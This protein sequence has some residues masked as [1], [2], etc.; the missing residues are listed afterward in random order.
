M[1]RLQLGVHPRV[2]AAHSRVM[3]DRAMGVE[4]LVVE[5]DGMASGVVAALRRLRIEGVAVA[6][7]EDAYAVLDSTRGWRGFLVDPKLGPPSDAGS[8]LLTAIASSK[9]RFLPRAAVSRVA[10]ARLVAAAGRVGARY[11][12]YPC[13]RDALVYFAFDVHASP[14]G[15]ASLRAYVTELAVASG[16]TATEL[17]I[18]V[19]YV[20]DKHDTVARRVGMKETTVASHVRAILTKMNLFD[21]SA[22]VTTMHALEAWIL[23]RAP[24]RS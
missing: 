9:H 17:V 4:V 15:E 11:L 6:S 13:D 24:R 20:T 23:R 16:L 12:C 5:S 14:I 21:P 18:L 7:A 8:R 22:G 2:D 19:A 1:Q 3:F 10:G